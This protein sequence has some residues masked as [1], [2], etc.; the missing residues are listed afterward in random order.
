M[1]T[2][3]MTLFGLIMLTEFLVMIGFPLQAATL[4]VDVKGVSNAQGMLHV[5]LYYQA[6]FF[7][8]EH[9]NDQ[10]Q[11]IPASS[12]L[13]GQASIKFENLTAGEYAIAGYHDVNS[14]DELDTN[15]VGIPSEPYGASLGARNMFSP[16][17]FE[18][19]KFQIKNQNKRISIILE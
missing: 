3:G 11:I 10:G 13:N 18:D 9:K 16:P 15:L 14:N 1:K 7:P 2:I 8:D 4:T 5:G 17:A 12:A 19:A 6:E